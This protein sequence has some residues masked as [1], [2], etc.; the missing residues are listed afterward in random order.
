VKLKERYNQI[1]SNFLFE[2]IAK[3]YDIF[4]LVKMHIDVPFFD[5]KNHATRLFRE[6]L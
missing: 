4:I 6:N 5:V 1:V 3:K 2:E